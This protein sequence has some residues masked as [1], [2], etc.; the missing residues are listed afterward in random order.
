MSKRVAVLLADGLEE[1]EAVTIIDV[2]RRAGVDV[3]A[4]GVGGT[5]ID[6]SHE[7]FLRADCAFAD[8]Q[9]EV[10]DAVVLPGGEP[11]TTNLEENPSVASFLK[12]HDDKG[13]LLGAICAAPRVLAEEG[14]L[15]GDPATSHP[16]VADRMD[17]TDYRTD[18]VVQSGRVF[19]SRGP[20][21]AIP[22]ALSLVEELAGEEKARELADYMEYSESGE[23]VPV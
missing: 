16:G 17:R 15:D 11:G 8:I 14:I 3:V 19:T 10:F 20:G 5:D 4:A 12:R 9:E 18:E 1:I 22:F 23:Q 7:I 2:L 6:G 13:K 21:T